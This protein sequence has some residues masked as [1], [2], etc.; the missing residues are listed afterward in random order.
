MPAQSAKSD[1][2]M[3]A[4]ARLIR[5]GQTVFS[6]VEGDLRRQGF[7]PLAWYDVLLELDRAGEKGLRPFELQQEI[8]LAQYNLSRLVERLDRAGHVRRAAVAEDGRGQRLS[9]TASGRELRRAMWPAYAAAVRR[10][11]GAALSDAE[12]ASLATL[13]GRL[14][15]RQLVAGKRKGP[16]R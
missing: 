1:A 10:H 9:I 12:A 13:L 7:P 8:L 4:W 5:A 11:F 14:T 16:S 15:E 3:H 2:I 6:A